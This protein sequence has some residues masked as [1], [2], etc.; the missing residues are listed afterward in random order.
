M[1]VYVDDMKAKYRKMTMCHMM[2]DSDQELRE[3]ATKIGVDLKWHQGDHFDICLAKRSLA[4]T[5]GA[6]EIT[7]RQ[8]VAVRKANRAKHA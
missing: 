1:S 8:M 3:M 4:I 7:Q 2:A 6:I 5:H